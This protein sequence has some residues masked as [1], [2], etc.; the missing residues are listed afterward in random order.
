MTDLSKIPF[1][2]SEF[3][4]PYVGT[5]GARPNSIGALNW[6]SKSSNSG[7]WDNARQFFRAY[8]MKKCKPISKNKDDYRDLVNTLSDTELDEIATTL[9][10]VMPDRSDMPVELVNARKSIAPCEAFEAMFKVSAERYEAL[11]SR[12]RDRM[13]VNSI[14]KSLKPFANT[15]L[16]R[17]FGLS[18]PKGALVE[19]LKIINS[20]DGLRAGLVKPPI[21]TVFEQLKL[22]YDSLLQPYRELGSS[23]KALTPVP[24]LRSYLDLGRIINTPRLVDQ[25]SDRF[26]LVNFIA[27]PNLSSASFGP[28]QTGFIGDLISRPGFVVSAMAG[29][30]GM[31]NEALVASVL[32]KFDGTNNNPS[33]I[34][35]NA[36]EV[37]QELDEETNIEQI[38]VL[39][40][41]IKN[42]VFAA[43]NRTHKMENIH[44]MLTIAILIISAMMLYVAIY[45]S[46]PEEV[47]S[48]EPYRIEFQEKQVKVVEELKVDP[49]DIRFVIGHWN[50]R[51]HPD[52]EA[53]VITTLNRDQIVK[54][55]EIRGNWARVNVLSYAGE[56][57][58][59]GWVHRDGL[60]A[61]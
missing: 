43:A 45:S 21:L 28:M 56:D 35:N 8:L 16:D 22:P 60:V 36:M 50:L 9:I 12:M 54:V 6:Y 14:K 33:K 55:V 29:I 24:H 53:T 18:R 31:A 44:V 49:T 34:F 26:R 5:V 10:E 13:S 52:T 48:L 27:S 38:V 37:L 25:I 23:M 19:V 7:C 41:D 40:A 57:G 2:S 15:N 32:S 51:T 20:Q 3:D 46:T 47:Q 11:S 39:L 17:R 42:Q 30:E 59:E 61:K 1:P 58:L 4:L